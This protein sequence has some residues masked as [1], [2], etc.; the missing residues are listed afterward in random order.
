MH[1]DSVFDKWHE[2]CGVFGIYDRHLN[3]GNFTYW[4][5]LRSNIAARKVP[6]SPSVMAKILK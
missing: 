3:I 5:Y 6:V 1:Y 4:A 2:E